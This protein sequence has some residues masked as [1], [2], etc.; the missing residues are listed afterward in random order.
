MLIGD[1]IA[2]SS[3]KASGVHSEIYS[4]PEA[5]SGDY[6]VLVRQVWGRIPAGRVTVD[7]WS[8]LG[9]DKQQHVQRVI[10]LDDA[11]ALVSFHLDSGR[12][13]E[14]LE[15]Q[16]L[17]NDVVQQVAINRTILAQQLEAITNPE[18]ILAQ[19]N[20]TNSQPASRIGNRTNP[21]NRPAPNAFNPNVGYQPQ[22][23]CCRLESRCRPTQ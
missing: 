8:H 9:S 2:E 21:L 14:Q 20:Y 22:L 1:P 10:P 6:R 18:V 17:A 3:D 11:G 16:Q 23:L 4:C 12:R 13:Q 7:V 5:F 19:Q 15:D